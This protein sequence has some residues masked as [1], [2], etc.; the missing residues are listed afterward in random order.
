MG[1]STNMWIFRWWKEL[2]EGL[3]DKAKVTLSRWRFTETLE[4][5]GDKS[6]TEACEFLEE[7]HRWA[8][9]EIPERCVVGDGCDRDISPRNMAR[10]TN[11]RVVESTRCVSNI[12]GVLSICPWRIVEESPQIIHGINFHGHFPHG[13]Q[14]LLDS[15]IVE[16]GARWFASPWPRGHGSSSHRLGSK[17]ASTVRAVLEMAG[18]MLEIYHFWGF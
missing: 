16:A 10:F 7:I 11:E 14:P 1:N 2:K 12:Y 13:K 5:G 18:D 17:R 6:A 9:W 15:H 4:N 8:P 3:V